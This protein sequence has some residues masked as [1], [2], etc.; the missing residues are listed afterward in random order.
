MRPSLVLLVAVPVFACAGAPVQRANAPCAE[1]CT[2]EISNNGNV[3]VDVWSG[4]PST[5]G[6]IPLGSVNAGGRLVSILPAPPRTL[7]TT[8]VM[9]SG[10]RGSGSC[11]FIGRSSDVLRYDCGTRVSTG[12]P[13]SAAS[14][15]VPPPAD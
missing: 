12:S 2:I 10:T 9:S 13:T 14:T 7:A 15:P 3:A 6:A 1:Q 5:A 4:Y 8:Y 11:D